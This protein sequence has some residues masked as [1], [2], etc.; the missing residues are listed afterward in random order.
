MKRGKLI[1][2]VL[3]SLCIL[4]IGMLTGCN[5]QGEKEEELKQLEFTVVPNEDIP[6]EFLENI[7]KEKEQEFK[8]SFT[9]E[10]WLYIA[11]GYGKQNSGGYSITVKEL[12]LAD[13]AVYFASELI[14][15][16]PEEAVNKLATYP[17]IVIKTEDTGNNVVFR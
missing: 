4:M 6:K 8:L 7:E 16:S 3:M 5:K 13:N 14:G 12:S 1:S 10:G 9:S 2:I 17:Y 15:P 11:R